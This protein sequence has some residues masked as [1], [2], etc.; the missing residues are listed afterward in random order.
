M[1]NNLLLLLQ[2]YNSS[3]PLGA[4]SYSEGLETL[5]EK[6]Q[7]TNITSLQQWLTNEIMYGSIRIESAIL[8]RSYNCYLKQD[9][10]GL[11]YWND[12][13]TAT[14][15]TQELREQSWQ[16]GRSLAR[17]IPSL[18]PNNPQLESA[19]QSLDSCCNYSIVLGIITAH[20]QIDIKEVL[21][22]FLHSWLTNQINAG[23]KLIPL[24]QTQGQKLLLNLNSIVTQVTT[25]IM[26]LTDDDLFSC[27][28]GLS[29][30][31]IEHETLYS[32]LFRS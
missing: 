8:I 15:E 29:W 1:S 14:R 18:I 28:W 11:V 32:R 20:W 19:R 9:T 17:L 25:E 31:S 26:T 16:M 2:L 30:A 5:V 23:I 12:W 6:N 4:Y 21:L 7:I 27:S 24:G 10:E 3:F 22:G 13:L